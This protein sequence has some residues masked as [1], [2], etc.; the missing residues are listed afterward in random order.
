M[1]AATSGLGQF[2]SIG[3]RR[4]E[5]ATSVD[6]ARRLE[7]KRFGFGCNDGARSRHP[8]QSTFA[9]RFEPTEIRRCELERCAALPERG[10]G[11][12]MKLRERRARKP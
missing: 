4:V 3:R 11:I 2:R 6:E 5:T 8:F 1:I 10:E 12:A 9:V 7:L